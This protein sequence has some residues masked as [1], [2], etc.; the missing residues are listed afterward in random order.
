MEAGLNT[1]A[2]R[3]L[4]RHHVYAHHDAYPTRTP[5]TRAL[6]YAITPTGLGVPS[7][8]NVAG[9]ANGA[10]RDQGNAERGRVVSRAM[11]G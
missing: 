10:V 6:P 9:M 7:R 8:A 3:A 4:P 2:L 1:L 11:V 5:I